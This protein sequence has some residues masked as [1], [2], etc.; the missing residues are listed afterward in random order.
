[1]NRVMFFAFALAMGLVTTDLGWGAKG[2]PPSITLVTGTPILFMKQVPTT[3]TFTFVV[4]SSAFQASS[5]K[6]ERLR[7]DGK[8]KH[9]A[10]LSPKKTA[11]P[12]QYTASFKF[13]EPTGGMIRVRIAATFT[14]SGKNKIVSRAFDLKV[15]QTVQPGDQ[16]VTVP[17]PPG[18]G[19]SLTIPG[20]AL[21]VPAEVAIAPAPSQIFDSPVAGR[22]RVATID[23]VF[24][25]AT[26]LDG[27]S[28]TAPLQVS[29][30]APAGTPST[31]K[32]Y[33]VTPV[34]APVIGGIGG[35]EQKQIVIDT[36]LVVN[37]QIVSQ[38]T[39]FEGISESGTYAV[40]REIGTGI[41]IGKICDAGVA[42][43]C[44]AAATPSPG[45]WVQERK[46]GT[47]NTNDLGAYTD[48]LGRFK[49]VV[50][51]SGSGADTLADLDVVD[52]LRCGTT[53][54]TGVSVPGGGTAAGG[55]VQNLFLKVTRTPV[56]SFTPVFA[57][58]RNG[59]FEVDRVDTGINTP[60][61]PGTCWEP[62]PAGAGTASLVKDITPQAGPADT[63]PL[64][65]RDLFGFQTTIRPNEG[66]QFV[67][68]RATGGYIEQ[69][70]LLPNRCVSTDP[71]C[72]SPLT[73]LHFDYQFGCAATDGDCTGLTG[74]AA[75]NPKLRVRLNGV[76]QPL[77][78]FR[79]FGGQ[80]GWRTG[81][82]DVSGFTPGST[83]TLRFTAQDLD[84][85]LTT[86]VLLDNVRFDTVFATINIVNNAITTA[87]AEEQVR[88]AN[89]IVSQSGTN[90]RIVKRPVDLNPNDAGD[91]VECNAN[92]DE[93]ND[94]LDVTYDGTRART[95]DI[96]RILCLAAK[97]N[98]DVPAK[99]HQV[100]LV[101]VERLFDSTQTV[102]GS[103]VTREDYAADAPNNELNYNFNAAYVANLTSLRNETGIILQDFG[104][105][106]DRKR[107]T[108]AHE[109]G[110]MLISKRR[111]DSSRSTSDLELEHA[112]SGSFV[113]QGGEADGFPD[114]DIALDHANIMRQKNCNPNSTGTSAT[115]K[116]CHARVKYQDT[117]RAEWELPGPP[118]PP[119]CPVTCPH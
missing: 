39:V 100:D 33:F 79:N 62:V 59:G 98:S 36:G 102:Y 87:T 7:A 88:H 6:L 70:F 113:E 93:L 21:E 25:P 13:N 48:A 67:A 49:I 95:E 47:I 82:L 24:E 63:H 108:L 52:G 80:L 92:G 8:W 56:A 12:L 83:L 30:P 64:D 3:V 29:V 81:E 106:E 107:E 9:E 51:T 103:A 23:I 94:P 42:G 54:Q 76:D 69:K 16:P 99:S 105:N 18:S 17:G 1:M 11:T 71:D 43:A 77:L 57:S 14:S 35:L 41:I 89:E 19:L 109:I 84:A 75:T 74:P 117:Q 90:I 58:L 26:P 97:L 34:P 85:T 104:S 4:S 86:A 118:D 20:G 44:N 101:F 10:N 112:V 15:G 111:S 31:A 119:R 2:P 22:P 72:K 110:H 5:T 115:D 78:E 60:V 40:L 61:P 45:V 114:R 91:P 96:K 46:T 38:G 73:N 65:Y 37:G 32:F 50:Q 66:D 27:Q 28:L 68:L 53:G 116:V 55:T